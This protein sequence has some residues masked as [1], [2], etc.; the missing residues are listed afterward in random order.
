[1][2]EGK[3]KGFVYVKKQQPEPVPEKE[4]PVT[5]MQML[6]G[7]L[8]ADDEESKFRR[9]Q[10]LSSDDGGN[11]SIYDDDD[12]DYKRIMNRKVSMNE[13]NVI[14]TNFEKYN[15]E[16][17]P[18]AEIRR[19]IGNFVME[20]TE[21]K[22]RVHAKESFLEI[23]SEGSVP[24]FNIVGY[25]LHNAF[26]FDQAG[27]NDFLELIIDHLF[28]Q[29]KLLS[30]DDLL[31]GVHVSL[32]NFIDTLI[33]YPMSRIYAGELFDRLGEKGILQPE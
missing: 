16:A 12:E 14:G 20:Y 5:P 6:L 15:R 28:T 4:S 30:Q 25:I 29:E 27:W 33:D 21:T 19:K 22:D 18:S 32:A 7:G 24:A 13:Q 23:C 26:S 9:Q 11:D 31:E 2:S 10:R 3:K 1:V 8:K 17:K